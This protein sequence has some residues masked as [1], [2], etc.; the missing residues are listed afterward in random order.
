MEAINIQIKVF[1]H[2]RIKVNVEDKNVYFYKNDFLPEVI[3]E[4]APEVKNKSLFGKSKLGRNSEWISNINDL[5]KQIVIECHPLNNKLSLMEVL[6]DYS[7]TFNEENPELIAYQIFLKEE[8]DKVVFVL[9]FLTRFIYQDGEF[10]DSGIR[11][12][13]IQQNVNQEGNILINWKN[14]EIKKITKKLLELQE[15]SETTIPFVDQKSSI[16]LAETAIQLEQEIREFAHSLPSVSKLEERVDACQSEVDQVSEQLTRVKDKKIKLDKQSNEIASF[17][18]SLEQQVELLKVKMEQ[19]LPNME[20]QNEKSNQ[21]KQQED[22]DELHDL[23]SKITKLEKANEEVDQLVADS[24]ARIAE[25]TQI[26]SPLKKEIVEVNKRLM[27]I[28]EKE[29]TLKQQVKKLNLVILQQ[30]QK[31]EAERQH[32]EGTIRQLELAKLDNTK[33][34]SNEIMEFSPSKELNLLTIKVNENKESNTIQE[35]TELIYANDD[36][37]GF[38]NTDD[39]QLA[40]AENLEKELN[41]PE[42]QSKKTNSWLK[43]KKME[44]AEFN[45]QFRKVQYLEHA[46]MV[47]RD[48]SK[49]TNQEQEMVEEKLKDEINQV[50]IENFILNGEAANLRERVTFK[51]NRPF[52]KDRVI[53]SNDDYELLVKK[54]RQYEVID[55]MN[56]QMTVKAREQV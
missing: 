47:H 36:I 49:K 50:E 16:K 23:R 9:N 56:K 5:V 18:S 13:L 38:Q 46:W 45:E 29:T 24:L 35:K 48:L 53:L 22:Q 55:Y 44:V 41:L 6:D 40:E 15:L 20:L 17:L 19:L 14:S 32:L 21:V 31:H 39:G 27:G 26:E 12:A 10:L 11:K 7:Q 2:E 28:T 34:I 1:S 3:L 52:A 30:N 54:A 4:L 8:A 42:K 51:N 37:V 33:K 43:A 25:Q